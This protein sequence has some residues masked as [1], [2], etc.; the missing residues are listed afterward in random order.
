MSW[1]AVLRDEIVADSVYAVPDASGMIKLDAMENPYAVPEALR[2]GLSQCLSEAVINRYPDAQATA[3]KAVL[4]D[5]AAVPEGC[6]VVVGNGSDELILMLS[7]LSAR[8][9]AC[10]LAPRPS[11]VMYAKTAQWAGQHFVGVALRADFSLD[12][13][14]MLEAIE[15]HQPALVY[16]SYP[17]NPT[18]NLF[19][20]EAVTAVIEAAPGLVVL[21]E[22]YQPFAAGA[23][24]M[25]QLARYE[26]LVV[27][28]TVSKLGLAGLRLG[29]LTACTALTEQIEKIRMPYNV[30][31]LT[32][33]AAR[34]CLEH[35]SAWQAQADVLCTERELLHHAIEACGYETYPSAA[36]FIL[37]RIGAQVDA[38]FA[39]LRNAGILVKNFSHADPLLQGCL[40]VSIGT[41]E[42]N[43]AFIRALQGAS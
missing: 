13:E 21:D 7:L 34:F 28:R 38:V 14:A 10:V 36:N 4:R 17:N 3:L 26:H 12:T 39:H 24:W 30:N 23:T 41:P 20:E 35:A 25:A 18:G 43:A 11:F 29:Y 32:Q 31:V 33:A 5:Y 9:G 37:C 22:A 27:L 1:R 2:E 15:A 8:E 6:D 42:E 16:L 19:D 40:R